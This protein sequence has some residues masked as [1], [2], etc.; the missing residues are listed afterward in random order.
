MSTVYTPL[1]TARALAGLDAQEAPAPFWPDLARAAAEQGLGEH[2][3]LLAWELCG[4]TRGLDPAATRAFALL[5]LAVLASFDEGSTRIAAA[6]DGYMRRFLEELDVDD[7]DVQA[8][9]EMLAHLAVGDVSGLEGVV[10]SPAQYVPLVVHQG[11]IYMQRMRMLE[12]RIVGSLRRWLTGEGRDI[13]DEI[14]DTHIEDVLARPTRVAD[15]DATL[16][17]DQIEAVRLCA[18]RPL[19]VISGG[20]GT[21]KTSIVVTI[22]RLFAR[23]GTIPLSSIALAAPTGKAADRMRTSI[24]RALG[25]IPQPHA[26]DRML[27]EAGLEPRTLHRLLGYSPSMDRFRHH[28]N[29]R[30][31]HGLVIVDESSMIDVFLMNR[32]LDALREDA[33]IVLLGDAE[34]LPSVEAGAVLRH[35]LRAASRSGCAQVL[36]HSYRMDSQDPSGRSILRVA[37]RINSGDT[38]GLLASRGEDVIVVR[39]RPQDLDFTGVRAIVTPGPAELHTVLRRF[40]EYALDE[41]PHLQR[42][43]RRTYTLQ[44]GRFQEA[45]HPDLH[46][47]FDHAQRSRILTVTRTQ[48]AVTSEQAVNRWFH[49]RH[50]LVAGARGHDPLPGEP[51]IVLRNDYERGLYNGDQGIVLRVHRRNRPGADLRAVFR[52]GEDFR[53]FPLAHLA[54]RI[55]LSH[56]ITVHRAQGSE[57]DHVL[58]VLPGTDM[59]MMTREIVYTAVTRARRSVTIAGDPDLVLAAAARPILRSSGIADALDES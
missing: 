16:S 14:L 59:R 19:A 22:L 4:M 8:V 24:E 34:Q 32:L 55:Q 12:A 36:T 25:S 44:D 7:G 13:D 52:T 28:E 39:Q 11:H 57:Y 23:L 50:P 58:L 47:L 6:M 17:D 27:L 31:E 56:A 45:D 46:A 43:S 38:D 33:H 29:N 20:P 35:L 51:V 41:G 18:R 54:S 2:K 30:L 5:V 48:G 9:E 40:E 26:T 42:A 3:L 53:A 15:A 10:G 21:G 49:G 1:G 37:G